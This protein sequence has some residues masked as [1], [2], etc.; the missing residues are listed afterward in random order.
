MDAAGQLLVD[1]QN[2]P[3]LA[4]LPVGGLRSGIFQRQAVL[5]NPLVRRF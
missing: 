5:V 1:L 3:H 2:L 4:V